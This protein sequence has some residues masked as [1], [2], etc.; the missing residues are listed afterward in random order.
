M[1]QT[2]LYIAGQRRYFDDLVNMLVCSVAF[3]STMQAFRGDELNFDDGERTLFKGSPKVL[4][5]NLSL[6]AKLLLDPLE[7]G[8]RPERLEFAEEPM[9]RAQELIWE[10]LPQ[11]GEVLA[12]VFHASFLHYY[13]SLSEKIEDA[14]G[15][16]PKD[17]PEVVRFGWAVRNAFAHN[18]QVYIKDPTVTAAWRGLA[19]SKAD[20][21]R[22]ILYSDLMP[23]E[24]IVLMEEMDLVIPR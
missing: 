12:P 24:L 8:Q 6:D 17:F 19:Y 7:R 20:N 9:G 10:P 15:K 5:F 14:Y 1:T 13:E 18:G 4:G 11:P 16:Q 23:A 2:R 22:Q 3:G 21:D